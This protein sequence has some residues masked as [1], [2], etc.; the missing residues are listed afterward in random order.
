MA[1]K[2]IFKRKKKIEPEK[3]AKPEKKPK[4]DKKEAKKVKK[5]KKAVRPSIAYGV[6]KAPHI[7]E[8]ATDLAEKRQYVFKVYPRSNKTKIKKAVEG[9]YSVKVVDVRIVNI[10]KKKRRLGKRT[11]WKKGYK[12]AIVK[13]EKGQKVE[14]LIH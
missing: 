3:K 2:D 9:L 14:G 13:I 5:E 10:P 1:L 11:G 12:K 4:E 7:T 6:L 8:K